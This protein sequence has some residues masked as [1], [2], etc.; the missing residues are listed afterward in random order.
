MKQQSETFKEYQ[1]HTVMKTNCESLYDIKE[2]VADFFINNRDEEKV[3]VEDV[4]LGKFKLSIY[5]SDIV[6]NINLQLQ[7][8]H[9][10]GT[11]E[12]ELKSL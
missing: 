4:N 6:H 2:L 12:S 3:T 7:V 1:T 11:L 10:G 8:A 5:A 9:F